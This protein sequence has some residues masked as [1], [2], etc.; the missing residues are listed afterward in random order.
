M[1]KYLIIFF[2]LFNV[3][4]AEVVKNIQIDGNSKI[5]DDTIL[6]YGD[7]DLNT[8][9]DTSQLNE[10]LKKLY[11]TE[12]FED[13]DLSLKNGLLKI[14][15]KEYPT[16]NSIEVE[17]EKADKIKE[18]IL[19]ILD[20]KEKS[21]FIKSKLSDDIN[22]I[23]KVYGSLGFTF[24]K[25]EAKIE[26]FNDNRLNLIFFVN[27]G[28]KT[29]IKSINFIGD[30]KIKDRRLR[31]IIV[32]EEKK[33]W[34]VLSK[35][36]SLSEA[37]LKLDKSLLIKYYK[38]RGYY[39]VQVIS[40]S[41][42]INQNN[43]T[44]LTF[45]IDA[46]KRY[47]ITKISTDVS[48]VFDKNIF[49]P[50]NNE[51]KKIIGK[52]YSPIHIKKLLDEL[53]RMISNNDLQFVEH[54]VNEIVQNNTI[55][56]KINIFEG[57]KK[58]VERIN[59]FGNK[60]T[61]ES[62]I[63]G[64][65]LLD[66]GDPF[67]KLRLDKSIAQLKARR[68][69]AN[70]KETVKEGSNK[71]LKVIDISLEE[72]PTGEIS[73]G[74]GI[75]TNGGT[76]AF[77]ITEN[78]WLGNGVALSSS[79]EVDKETLKGSIYVSNPNYNYS[80]N[81]VNANFSAS[82]N[83]KSDSGYKNK[84]TS[85]GVGTRFEQYKDIYVSPRITLTHDNLS[86][87]KTASSSLK[88]QAGKFVDLTLDYAVGLDKRDR[89]FMPT[90]GYVSNFGQQIPIYADSPFIK[91]TFSYSAY[92]S[93]GEDIIGTFKFYGAAINGIS[94]EDVRISKRINMPASRLRGFKNGKV[95]PKDGNDYVG[96]NYSTAVNI[97]SNL[98]N[99]LPES[100]KLDVGL[101]LDFGNVWGVDYDDTLDDSNKIR[102]STGLNASWMS[103]VGPMSFVFAKSITKAAT[104]ETEGFN[105]R[106]GTTF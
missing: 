52:Y 20:L 15:I 70:I 90:Q 13:I 76:F 79:V 7:I 11:S 33:F 74:A 40:S 81:E 28:N 35:N 16:I 95:G 59:I 103:P 37:N 45:N 42:E 48:P 65:L 91:N 31:D 44:S 10:I 22:K 84:I 106:L 32:S 23:K 101:F 21:S 94:N 46:G 62:V 100:T 60:V 93:F 27:K 54:S 2:L 43:G 61:N 19:K 73:A 58:L 12:F 18:A 67:S 75:G 72:K 105:F 87:S 50:L 86:V 14:N 39:D 102:S 68:L 55:E 96:G 66:E 29:K 26:N 24:V 5:S 9:Y 30:K 49:L 17:G 99:L 3:V 41:A 53:D 51:Y 104:D 82:D 69:F 4:N 6:V 88:N 38:S 98:P 1:K 34:K 80:G 56:V 97:E 25:V 92:N 64:E 78:N 57:Q 36:T 89:A 77:D 63:R 8:D 47:K 85:T 83:D 71:D